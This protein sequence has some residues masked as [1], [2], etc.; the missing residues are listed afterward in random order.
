MFTNVQ[1]G[2]LCGAVRRCGD[3]PAEMGVVVTLLEL[4]ADSGAPVSA[5]V[6]FEHS[7]YT[8][9]K[10][11][12]RVVARLPSVDSGDDRYSTVVWVAIGR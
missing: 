12:I 3:R 5:F 7:A 11:E 9:I 8:L 10:G 1:R 2:C 4:P 6:A